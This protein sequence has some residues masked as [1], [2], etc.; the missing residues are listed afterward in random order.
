MKQFITLLLIC[1]VLLISCHK[2]TE[3]DTA[4]YAPPEMILIHPEGSDIQV[5]SDSLFSFEFF[6]SAEA[7]LNTFSWNGNPITAF[8]NGET[9]S[10]FVF[11][12]YFWESGPVEFVL[13][14]LCNQATSITLNMTV[15][16]PSY[17]HAN[18]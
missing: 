11:S 8:T 13:H 9:E 1:L 3:C 18:H 5:D 14:D 12:S 7:G 4:G 16:H 10:E 15:I 2:E 17:K 6:L